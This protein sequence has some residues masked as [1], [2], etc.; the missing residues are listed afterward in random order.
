LSGPRR[1]IERPHGFAVSDDRSVVDESP[2]RLPVAADVDVLVV[3]GGPAGVGAALAAGR[4]GARTLLVERHAM[5]GGMW[6]AGM[7][8]PL[9]DFRR[10]GWLVAELIERLEA[11]GAW[12]PHSH[13]STFDC[14]VMVRLLERLMDEAG[15]EFRYHVSGVD[16][17][18]EDGAVRGVVTESKAGRRA[19]LAGAVIDCTGDGDVAARA[20]VP[21]ELG[22][23]QDG[24]LQPMTL[25]FE[26]RGTG[27]CEQGV[28]DRRHTYDVMTEVIEENDLGVELPFGRVGYAPAIIKMPQPDSAVVQATHVYRLNALDPRDLTR[29]IVDARRQA[30]ELTEVIRHMPG[31][32]DVRLVRTAPTIGIRETRRICGRYRLDEAD[33]AEGRRFEDAVTFCTFCVDVHEPAPGAGLPSGHGMAMKPYEIPFRCLLPEGV[34]NLL[35]AG[36]CISGSHIAHAS[37]RVTGNCM[38]MG[39]AAGLAAAMATAE[40]V[41]PAE[42]PGDRLK[43]ELAA[44]GAGFLLDGD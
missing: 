18:I 29:G 10:K 38:A 23:M 13:R 8:N 25:M 28:T 9:F 14:E 24:L 15:V 2:R 44:R 27:D 11:E 34:D 32:E 22:R 1:Q 42:V 26:I 17:I 40:G 20:G 19:V 5:L 35:V 21:Y 39:Q 31:L 12:R 6:T 3:G 36:R 7:V 37:Y 33:L 43:R 30:A 16:T 4:E 41:S